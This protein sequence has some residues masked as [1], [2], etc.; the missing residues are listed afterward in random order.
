MKRARR[1]FSVNFVSV[2]FLSTTKFTES[3]FNKYKYNEILNVYLVKYIK[4]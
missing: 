2:S 3:N 4:Y 1:K